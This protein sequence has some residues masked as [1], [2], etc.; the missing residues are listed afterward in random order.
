MSKS[1]VFIFSLPRSGSTLLQRILGAHPDISTAAEP[2]IL[3]P[4]V[5]SLRKDGTFAQYSHISSQNAVTDILEQLPNG[6]DDYYEGLRLFANTIY[7]Q[8]NRENTKYFLDKTP[9]YYLISDEI[10]KIYPEA[11]FI[12]L[13]RNPLAVLASTIKSFYRDRLGDWRHKIDL[14][15]GPVMLSQGYQKLKDRSIAIQYEDLLSEPEKYISKICEYLEIPYDDSLVTEFSKTNLK[16]SM[17]DQIGTSKYSSL[18][19]KTLEKWRVTL[20]TFLRKKYAIKYLK[21][22]GPDT[23]SNLGYDMHNL[24]NEVKMLDSKKDKFITD[25]IQLILCEIR[26]FF[27]IPLQKQNLKKSIVTKDSR[28]VHF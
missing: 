11:K 18:E 1:P 8:L 3:L 4:F 28:Y 24:I 12:F 23:V 2:W 17:G 19:L 6:V 9:R 7:H 5:Y 27:E 20:R 21:K 22:L 25:L 10:S 15:Q 16:G 26:I 13:F 14:F